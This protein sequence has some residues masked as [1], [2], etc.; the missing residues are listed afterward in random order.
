MHQAS[1]D[2]WAPGASW[3]GKGYLSPCLRVN[4]TLLYGESHP[5]DGQHIGGNAI[6]DRVR[7]S[8]AN[9]IAEAFR[10]DALQLLVDHSFLPE[11][12]LAILHPFKVGGR[13]TT[14]I[15]QNVRNDEDLLVRQDL[16]GNSC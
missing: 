8:V 4:A 9:H 14:G 11:I 3:A 1:A 16:V 13:D 7:L 5:V 10:Q 6:V 2:S 12:A 15:G